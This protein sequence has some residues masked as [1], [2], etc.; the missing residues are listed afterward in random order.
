MAVDG[1]GVK[2]G[3]VG[4]TDSLGCTTHLSCSAPHLS[5]IAYA[6][7]ALGADVLHEAEAWGL[8]LP[9]GDANSTGAYPMTLCPL[10]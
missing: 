5:C 4:I 6:G 3:K 2:F 10:V 8:A 9:W 1:L 7:R